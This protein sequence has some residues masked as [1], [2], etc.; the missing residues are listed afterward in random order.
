M[1]RRIDRGLDRGA[2]FTFAFDGQPVEAYPGETVGAALLA[3]GI[4]RFRITARSA[5]PR[6]L[7]CGM[8]VCWECL[9]TVDGSPSVRACTTE[10]RPGMRVETQHG[11]G[12]RGGP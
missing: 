9:V 1:T 3:A 2:A 11:A 6:G 5:M 8:G 12:R 10:A 4:N 7:Y